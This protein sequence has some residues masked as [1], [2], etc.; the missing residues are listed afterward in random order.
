MNG[1]IKGIPMSGDTETI[2]F[3]QLKPIGKQ[4]QLGIDE[5]KLLSNLYMLCL[6]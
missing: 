4:R 1:V 3:A 6:V 5:R 2:F